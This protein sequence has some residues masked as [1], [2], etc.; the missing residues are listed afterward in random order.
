MRV[1]E[2]PQKTSE[3]RMPARSFYIPEGISEYKLLNGEWR[4]AFFKSESDV[5]DKISRWDTI[6]VPSCWQLHGYEN[7]NYINVSYPF[8]CDLPYVPDDNPC[9]VY[10]RE[11]EVEKKWG[12]LYFVFEGVAS[13]AFLYI[14][15]AYV[16]FTQG[17][18]MQAE[19][20][21]T[22]YVKEGMNTVR[23]KVLKWCCGTYLESQDMFRYNGIFRDCY[24]L[25]RPEG[26]IEDIEV[27]PR[28]KEFHIKLNGKATISIYEGDKL[29][30][31]ENVLDEYTYEVKNP[32]MWN[33]EAPFLYTIVLERQG[34]IIHFKAGLRTVEIS[35][36]YE[37][38]VNGVS[39]KLHGVNRHDTSKYR[40]WCQT[41]EE[42]RKDLELMKELNI[43]CVRTAHYPP[44]PRF[45]ELCDELGFYVICEA[46]NETHGILRRL[47]TH[48]WNYD[49]DSDEWPATLPEWKKE[50]VERMQRMVECYK[51]YACIIMWSTGNECCYG[52]NHWEMIQYTRFRDNSR[53]IH[54]E[55]AS[56]KGEIRSAD[57]YSRMYV[58]LDE[59]ERL[60]NCHDINMP[61]FL[62]EYSHAMGNGPGDVYEYNELFDKYPKLIGGC[63]WEWA[64]HVVTVDGVEKYGG[65]FKGEIV[66]DSN[67]C[68]DGIVFADRS[69]KAGSY[70][71]KAAYQPIRTDYEE[72]K[73][74]VHNR[75]DFTN[76]N[77]FEFT[78]WI[79]VDGKKT[80]TQKRILDVEPHEMVELPI[81]Y[82]DCK[83][84]YGAT[85]NVT[86]SREGKI[87]A[88]TQHVLP[89][90]IN[91]EDAED[92]GCCVDLKEDA[93]YIYATGERFSYIFSKHH[94]TFASMIVDGEEQLAAEVKLSAYKAPTDNDRHI[95]SHW[96]TVDFW[97]GENMDYAFT[98]IYD[99]YLKEGVIVVEASLA[100]ISR[101]PLLKY[102]LHIR[103]NNFGRIDFEFKGKVREDAYW[104]PRLGFEFEMPEKFNE[105]TYY[106]R[107]PIE[108]YRD[109]CHGAF[110]GQYQCTAQ[111]EYVNYVRPQEHGNHTEVK[112]LHIGN[113]EFTS[114]TGFETNVSEYSIRAI[115]LA[116][117]TDELIK[118]GHIHV[119][120]DYKVSGLGSGSCGPLVAEE[121]RLQEKDIDFSFSVK[122]YTSM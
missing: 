36:K 78:Y 40:G 107:G 86:L 94:G 12:K 46:D 56:R 68:C 47:P 25:Q 21:I 67:F 3:N 61:I 119:R 81:A 113:L 82:E 10:E 114:I 85:L 115:D 26:H 71:T 20:D 18:H 108:N 92:S 57:V 74:T 103:I 73:L 1:Y 76:L 97:E 89:C 101:K 35:D 98:K 9:G 19:F 55:D 8:P 111:A 64:D 6:P 60:A 95:K 4:F 104:L 51:N 106:G 110:I 100:G 65:D 116:N 90:T 87:Y 91:A 109:M 43:N 44:T 31:T 34:E 39:V 33:A 75:L 13:C 2:N 117:H 14:N 93:K 54:C 50:H 59:L 48:T 99:C 120:I 84:S 105:F 16:G 37:L 96:S 63:I 17:S 83:C 79:E 32:I 52:I 41:D 112:I 28:E 53:L 58:G 22:K 27:I 29:L 15:G 11:F 88:Q 24:I 30:T 7:P 69:L 70:E 77:N 5:T 102:M 23:V 49:V 122:P 72:N 45:I 80:E 121:H 66:H 42:I 118:D 62:C 38:L